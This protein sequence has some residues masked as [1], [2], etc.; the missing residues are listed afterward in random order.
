[1]RGLIAALVGATAILGCASAG[2]PPGGPEDHA[3]PEILSVTPD[4]GET[5]VKV[6]SVEF[7]FDEVVSDLPSGATHLDQIFLIS[8]R[9]GEPKVSWHRTRIDLRPKNGFKPNTAY[10]ITMLPGLADL[11][12][13]VRRSTT[14]IVFSTGPGF[15]SLS[16]PGIVF[17]WAQQRP[18]T[19]AYVEA[20]WAQD[21]SVAYLGAT[22]TTGRFDLGPLPAGKYL[23]RAII[24]ANNN[25]MVDRTEKWDTTSIT[26]ADTRPNVE[27]DVIERDSVPATIQTVTVLDSVTLRVSF[28]KPLDPRTPLQPTLVRMHRADS[29]VINVTRVQWQTEYDREKAVRDSARRA[30]SI[31]ALPRPAPGA[32]GAPPPAQPAAPPPTPTPTRAAPPPP[33]PRIP[34]PDRGIV[35]TIAPPATFAPNLTYRVTVT[36]MRNLVGKSVP[37]TRSFTVPKPPPPRIVT[38]TTKKPP[39][40]PPTPP[41]KPPRS[42]G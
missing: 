26:V 38:D 1:V 27:L 19:A 30:D 2:T 31:K 24:D 17:D 36:G 29:S 42:H 10:R 34:P 7:K 37:A 40:R 8:P 4:S 12:G 16:I 32:P 23:V 9:N 41:P 33:K 22:D 28:D 13:N 20:V 3:P 6:K 25:R 14:S 21:T 15:P 35:I 11:R 5:N 39:A 18:A